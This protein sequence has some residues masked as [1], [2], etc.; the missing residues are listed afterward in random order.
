MNGHSN[1]DYARDDAKF[2]K[3]L[4]ASM[5][6]HSQDPEAVR[7]HRLNEIAMRLETK[8]YVPT[9]DQRAIEQMHA[10]RAAVEEPPLCDC[11]IAE[12]CKAGNGVEGPLVKC[13]RHAPERLAAL[14][15]VFIG[16]GTIH[17][18]DKTPDAPA[19]LDQAAKHMRDR[20][21]TYD[22]PEGERSM[23]A[24][25]EA[26]NAITGRDLDES[27]GWLLM[28]VLKMV[29]S[30]QRREPHRDSVEDLVAYSA[31]FGEAR[32]GGR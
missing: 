32:L 7:K 10:E 22:K 31:L 29:R 21:E 2:L 11:S 27:E 16:H 15:R 17:I 3:Q 6:Y 24:T 23:A 20:A 4:A 30:Q 9:P 25:V 13:R 18:K 8:F 5:S 19:L 28:A 26:F 1:Y 14:G 12:Q